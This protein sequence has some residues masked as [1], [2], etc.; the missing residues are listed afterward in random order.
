MFKR[1]DPLSD[2]Y[3]VPNKQAGPNKRA[4]GKNLKN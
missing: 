4:G 1:G 2:Y 3:E